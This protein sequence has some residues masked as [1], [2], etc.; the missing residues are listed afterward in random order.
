MEFIVDGV[1]CRL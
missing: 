1:P